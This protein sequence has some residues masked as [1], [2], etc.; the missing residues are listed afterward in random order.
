MVTNKETV[1]GEIIEEI[2]VESNECCSRKRGGGAGLF[3]GTVLLVWGS[4]IIADTY[5]GTTLTENIWPMLA[6]VF[7]IYLIGSSFNR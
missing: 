4:A 6:V 2:R 3:F 7:G 1:E 5:F